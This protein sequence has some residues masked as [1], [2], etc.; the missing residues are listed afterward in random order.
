MNHNAFDLDFRD[1]V[2]DLIELLT[3]GPMK[4]LD[5]IHSSISTGEYDFLKAYLLLLICFNYFLLSSVRDKVI[6]VLKLLRWL[7]WKSTFT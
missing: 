5:F 1:P 2:T 3:S 6:T 7:L 4:V